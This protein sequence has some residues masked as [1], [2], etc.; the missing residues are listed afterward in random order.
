MASL[1]LGQFQAVPLCYNPL[2]DCIIPPRE[3]LG[4]LSHVHQ[5]LS[6]CNE[7]GLQLSNYSRFFNDPAAALAHCTTRQASLIQGQP[8]TMS[9]VKN[10]ARDGSYQLVGAPLN[11]F[12]DD[13]G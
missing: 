4:E 7:P 13:V 9:D 5:S 2:S 1:E 12:L 11:S 6:F 10:V 8:A 3:L